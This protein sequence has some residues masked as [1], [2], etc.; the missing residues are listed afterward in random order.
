MYAKLNKIKGLD[1]RM[2]FLIGKE[3]FDKEEIHLNCIDR[4]I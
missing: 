4:L 3:I 1:E 2:K